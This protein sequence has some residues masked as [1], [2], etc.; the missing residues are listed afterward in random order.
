MIKKEEL[1]KLKTKVEL[2]KTKVL[3]TFV[4][5][6]LVLS[7]AAITGCSSDNNDGPKQTRT[8]IV[9]DGDK[10]VLYEMDQAA[11]RIRVAKTEKIQ[12][13]LRLVGGGFVEVYDDEDTDVIEIMDYDSL[14]KAKNV[15]RGLVGKE[16]TIIVY[17]EEPK[18]LT[19]ESDTNNN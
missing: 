10:A 13:G 4:G 8:A 3:P 16:G 9:V 6:S 17:G 2:L 1:K 18:T 12:V 15:A 5:A 14:E 19:Y 7:S 11:I